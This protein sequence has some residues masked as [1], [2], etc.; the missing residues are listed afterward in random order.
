MAAAA[1]SIMKFM[2]T[3]TI[4][5]PLNRQVEI[6]Y[7]VESEVDQRLQVVLTQ[8]GVYSLYSSMRV[9]LDMLLYT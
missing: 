5:S 8:I 1:S 7:V 3:V 2:S 9:L 4:N 6:C